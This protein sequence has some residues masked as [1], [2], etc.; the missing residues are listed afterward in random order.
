MGGCKNLLVVLLDLILLGCCVSEVCL[1]D[2]VFGCL[3][4][5]VCVNGLFGWLDSFCLLFIV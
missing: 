3:R 1:L 5:L 2:F 4:G